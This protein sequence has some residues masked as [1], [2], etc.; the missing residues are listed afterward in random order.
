MENDKIKK[1]IQHLLSLSKS[2]NK[3]EAHI[4]LLKANELMQ[5][6]NLSSQDIYSSYKEAF[7]IGSFD[8]QPIYPNTMSPQNTKSSQYVKTNGLAYFLNLIFAHKLVSI[9]AVVTLLLYFHPMSTTPF[10]VIP[11]TSFIIPVICIV[12][13]FIIDCIE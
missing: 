4:A 7:S 1:R 5:K 6:Y 9:A 8:N 11:S 13:I 10:N 3:N 2:S 12:G